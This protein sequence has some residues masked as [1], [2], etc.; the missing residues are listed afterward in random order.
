[1]SGSRRAAVAVF[2]L[3]AAAALADEFTFAADSVSST[4]AKGKERTILAGNAKIVSDTMT[5]TADTIELYGENYRFALCSGSVVAVDEKKGMRLT[6][7]HLYYDRTDKVSRMEGFSTLEDKKNKL[8]VKGGYIENDE[9]S[10]TAIIRIG[11]RVLKE[12]MAT[13]SEYARYDRGKKTFELSGDPT[14]R[15]KGD[16]YAADFITVNLDTEE[17][18]MKGAVKGTLTKK[19]EKKEG[20]VPAAPTEEEEEEADG[21]AE[22][23]EGEAP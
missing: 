2:A 8:V 18:S 23:P 10:D 3:C 6:T 7:N 16:D 4:R 1:M 20:T 11:V 12:D 15:W 22:T 21:P 13:R 9:R 19:E 5:I 17:I 14:V